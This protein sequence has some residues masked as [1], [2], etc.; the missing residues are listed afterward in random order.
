MAIL[1]R[2]FS[3]VP[4]GASLPQP[5]DVIFGTNTLTW[6]DAGQF[7]F[8]G[9]SG[10]QSIF[11]YGRGS[12]DGGDFYS[13]GG[14]NDFFR[15]GRY[16]D[17][18]FGG[19][20][21]DTLYGQNGDDRLEGGA[22]DD[23]LNG[24]SN[25]DTLL[26]GLGNDVLLGGFGD[27]TLDGGDGNDTISTSS[28]SHL[29]FGGAGDDQIVA[30]S[31]SDTLHGGAG[32]DQINAG[33]G[34]DELTG[35]DGNDT[36]LASSGDDFVDGGA[37]DD[38]LNGSTGNDLVSYATASAAVTLDLGSSEAQNTTGADMDTVIGFEA[39]EGS[40]YGDLLIGTNT[41]SNG[42]G[43]TNFLDGG[44]GSDTLVGLTGNDTIVGGSGFDE[45]Y[46]TSSTAGSLDN[47]LF[48]Y[49]SP[50]E[51][52]ASGADTILGFTGGDLASGG[53]IIDLRGVFDSFGLGSPYGDTV[54]DFLEGLGQAPWL[55]FSS[56]P[57]WATGPQSAEF[58]ALTYGFL[59]VISSSGQPLL[60]ID[61]DGVFN[62]Y[63]EGQVNVAFG[64]GDDEFVALLPFASGFTEDNFLV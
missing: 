35:G 3:L 52:S 25:N 29:A 30:S 22:G 4:P 36:I 26:G 42:N 62:F 18:I 57:P 37:G 19:D 40:N 17:T 46:A 53:D 60:A 47:D 41:D 45:M 1:V 50:S 54:G 43:G 39:A 34:N 61:P 33:G 5:Q 11:D 24:G 58:I 55:F 10:D 56:P 20:D 28:G 64:D 14:G 8:Y 27:D 51:L 9:D 16:N 12:G 48:G 59:S 15:A 23:I 38:L 32:N 63:G 21:N 44:A 13:G 2:N 49:Q 6:R 31:G 7:G